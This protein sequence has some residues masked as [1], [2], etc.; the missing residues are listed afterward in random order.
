[1]EHLEFRSLLQQ[2]WDTA[3]HE[4]AMKNVWCKLKQLKSKLKDINVYMASYQ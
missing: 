2:V 1:M 4:Q 3:D